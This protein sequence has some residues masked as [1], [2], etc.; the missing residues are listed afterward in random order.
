QGLAPPQRQAWIAALGQQCF[1]SAVIVLA[2]Q[3]LVRPHA[4]EALNDVATILQK[5][6]MAS[7]AVC[8]QRRLAWLQ[9]NDLQ[10]LH[11]LAASEQI[12]GNFRAAVTVLRQCLTLVESEPERQ[13]FYR[14][15][16]I[17][18]GEIATPE[19]VVAE[20]LAIPNG[21]ALLRRHLRYCLLLDPW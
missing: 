18:L 1:F 14:D 19:E 2:A 15:L 3:T 13:A 12:V 4:P 7:V 20:F 9:L 17:V 8:L 11:A 21:E 6:G 16:L 10:I 5:A